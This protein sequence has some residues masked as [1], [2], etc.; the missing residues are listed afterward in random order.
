MRSNWRLSL[1]PGMSTC[2]LSMDSFIHFISVTMG[3][4]AKPK[5]HME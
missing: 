4:E 3:I 2:H 5:S 1:I